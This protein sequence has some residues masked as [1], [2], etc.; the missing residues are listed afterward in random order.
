MERLSGGMKLQSY[1]G[2]RERRICKNDVACF[3][4][5]PMP[6]PK[7][8]LKQVYQNTNM[9]ANMNTKQGTQ[10]IPNA[11]NLQTC[12]QIPKNNAQL[13]ITN[14]IKSSQ[15]DWPWQASWQH[16]E[17]YGK[18]KDQQK[19]S[20]NQKCH[21]RHLCGATLIHK[22]WSIPAAHCIKESGMYINEKNPGNNWSVVFGL[23]KLTEMTNPKLQT[24][25]KRRFI[26]K[27]IVHPEYKFQIITFAD[28]ALLQ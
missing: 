20:Q 15:G 18:M 27:V 8:V 25:S 10:S 3:L 5:K 11:L 13:R 12:G 28:V 24:P 1:K 17:C 21:W 19:E 7:P 9:H 16:L 4:P 14:G 6:K 23:T 2:E 22:K 26:S